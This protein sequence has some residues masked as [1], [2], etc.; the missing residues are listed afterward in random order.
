MKQFTKLVTAFAVTS[1]LMSAVAYAA[2]AQTNPTI[3][4]ATAQCT[5]N[6]TGA[7]GKRHGCDSEIQTVRAPD[8]FVLSQ[9]TLAGGLISG[10]GSEQECHVTWSEMIDVI[11]GVAQPRVF[12]LRAHARSPKGHFAGRGWATCKYSVVLVPVAK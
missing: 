9:N 5:T 6:A 2:T 11:P 12:T 10:S 1:S 4:T 7:D 8:G 3:L